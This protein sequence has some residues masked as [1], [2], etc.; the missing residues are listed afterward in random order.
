[1]I[2]CKDG[3]L[4]LKTLKECIAI[5]HYNLQSLIIN[6][7]KTKNTLNRHSLKTFYFSLREIVNL[8]S[9]NHLLLPKADY[10]LFYKG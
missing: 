9:K 1:M 10:D 7:F 4:E 8:W 2:L 5:H 6:A 3:D